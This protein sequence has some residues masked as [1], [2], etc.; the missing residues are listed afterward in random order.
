MQTLAPR[1]SASGVTAATTI[2][3]G[4]SSTPLPNATKIGAGMNYCIIRLTF[5]NPRQNAALDD[6]ALLVS[7]LV[8]A[9]IFSSGWLCQG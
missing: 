4:V 2:G 1:L 3:R 8:V 5:V 6:L 9:E 7:L